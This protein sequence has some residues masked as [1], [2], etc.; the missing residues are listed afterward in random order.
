MISGDWLA[1]RCAHSATA[2]V[3]LVRRDD[4]VDDPHPPRLVRVDALAEQQQLAA[5][6][7]PDVAREQRR[8]HEREQ[9][10]V[11]LRRAERRALARDDEVAG[12]REPERAGEHVAAGRADHRLAELA[13]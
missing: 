2:R 9:A 8:D 12:Q 7:A 13:R 1:S 4:A 3:E 5:R 11:D 10:D 6:L